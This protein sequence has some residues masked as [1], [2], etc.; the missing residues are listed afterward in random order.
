MFVQ[1]G[2]SHRGTAT[3]SRSRSRMPEHKPLWVVESIREKSRLLHPGCSFP[4]V[5]AW[6]SKFP[7]EARFHLEEGGN[8]WQA[9][10]EGP[11]P[12]IIWNH[13]WEFDKGPEAF[14][15][16]LDGALEEG[17][18]FRLALLGE[19]LGI[20][21]V[22]AVRFGCLPLLPRRPSYPELIPGEF[23]RACLCTAGSRRT[24]SR[25]AVSWYRSRPPS[26]R[27]TLTPGPVPCYR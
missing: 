27:L 26:C 2:R 19:N 20:S 21:V 23:H 14:F 13:W 24:L 22:E 17:S 9:E 6:E 4:P 25:K 16:A 18:E 5:F 7:C 8:P 11:P 12:L 1:Q 15:C 3:G 10:R